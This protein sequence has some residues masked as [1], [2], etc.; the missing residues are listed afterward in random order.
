MA[1][2]KEVRSLDRTAGGGRMIHCTI[3]KGK[4]EYL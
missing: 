2:L 3:G 1:E 4:N